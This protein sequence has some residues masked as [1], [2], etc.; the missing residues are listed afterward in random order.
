MA[1]LGRNSRFSLNG[2]TTKPNPANSGSPALL[3]IRLWTTPSGSPN[4]AGGSS[5]MISNSNRNLDLAIM[6]AAVGVDSIITP[7][8]ASPPMAFSSLSGWH[9]PPEAAAPSQGSDCRHAPNPSSSAAVPIRPERHAA[10][11]IA[12]IRWHIAIELARR[13][14]RCPCCQ[15]AFTEEQQCYL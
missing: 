4:Y 10:D 12:T 8:C 9:L 14:P 5:A 7:A 1:N 3:Q 15:R 11:S 2:P 13:L 6:K